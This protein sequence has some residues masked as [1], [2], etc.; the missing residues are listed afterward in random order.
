MLAERRY[1]MASAAIDELLNGDKP[2]DK[3]N[4]I[5]HLY[6]FREITDQILRSTNSNSDFQIKSSWRDHY[7]KMRSLFTMRGNGEISG[8]PT[9]LMHLDHYWGGLQGQTAYL[10]LGRPGDAKSFSLA[11]LAVEG[12]WNGYRTAFF[13]PEM[14]EFA[15]N[16]RFHTLLSAKPQVQKELGLTGPF[17]NRAL[18]DGRGFNA[19]NYKR[20]LEWMETD[21][22]GEITLFTTKYRREKMNTAYID[23]RVETLGIDLVIVDPI[24]K[25]KPPRRRGSRWEEL[26]EIVDSLTDLAHTHN[27]PVVMSNQANR[28]MI[29]KDDAPHMN[30]SYG[31]DAPVQEADTVIGVRHYSEDRVLKFKCSKNRYGE[32]FNF[33]ARFE[34]NVGICQDVTPLR[35]ERGFD[36][37]A[38][39]KLDAKMEE[40][41]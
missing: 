30:S 26:G 12:A 5:E 27:I 23:Q 18:M 39:E 14:S 21:L 24:Y 40:E 2:L 15:H 33:A 3:D 19:K 10:W 6:H 41:E 38:L 35:H 8:I 25:L 7:R 32:R 1:V 29:G 20:F 34:P 28:A 22:K 9:G 36:T 4:V 11:Q 17:R 16:C 37:D 13:S 31:S